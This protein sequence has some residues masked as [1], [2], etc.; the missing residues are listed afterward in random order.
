VVAVLV[1]PLHDRQRPLFESIMAVTVAA[2]AV[3]TP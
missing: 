3:A 1:F 2:T